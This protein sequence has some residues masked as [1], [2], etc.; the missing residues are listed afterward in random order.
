MQQTQSENG[1][2]MD[3]MAADKN[4]KTSR[5]ARLMIK[6]LYR[7][8]SEK[9]TINLVRAISSCNNSDTNSLVQT[10]I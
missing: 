4:K 1:V 2:V 3:S 9:G 7:T 6:S 5:K 8:W 10:C